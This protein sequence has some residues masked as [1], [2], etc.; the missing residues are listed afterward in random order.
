[1]ELDPK[2]FFRFIAGA[3]L[4]PLA[5]VYVVW[6][7]MAMWYPTEGW[8]V[9]SAAVKVLVIA[10]AIYSFA[11]WPERMDAASF[12]LGL[13]MFPLLYALNPVDV[14]W[15]S[16]QGYYCS[17]YECSNTTWTEYFRM[18]ISANALTIVWELAA[19]LILFLLVRVAAGKMW[20]G[21]RWR[22]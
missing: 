4:A 14:V 17:N 13:L 3:A 21:R 11:T 19:F 6:P 5:L 2:Y 20:P 15:Q 18:L 9:M 1:M 10:G 16:L 8:S 12:V 7:G 22:A